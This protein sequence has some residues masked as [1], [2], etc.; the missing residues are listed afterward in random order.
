[1]KKLLTTSIL[2]STLVFADAQVYVGVLGGSDT[3]SFSGSN[4]HATSS[5]IAKLQIGYGDLK[6][7]SIQL[8]L[9]YNQNNQNIFAT[10]GA[11]DKEKY[12]LDVDLIKAFDLHLGLYPFLKVG[13]GAG[14]FGTTMNYTN[15]DGVPSTKNSLN[16]SSY[17]AGLGLYY[18][19]SQHFTLEAGATYQR[20]N[21]EKADT[22]STAKSV[23]SDAILSSIGID[24]RF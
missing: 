21:Y 5:P 22:S 12:A 6:A 8:G 17:D 2:L 13:V 4:S 7:Y 16:F 3:E 20:T 1:M 19:I 14:I 15:I 9:I 11:K 10:D 23:H 24:Y 18:P